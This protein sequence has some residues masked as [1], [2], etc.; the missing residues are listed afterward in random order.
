MIN[1]AYPL[2]VYEQLYLRAGELFI[3]FNSYTTVVCACRV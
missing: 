2:P 3:E 1:K